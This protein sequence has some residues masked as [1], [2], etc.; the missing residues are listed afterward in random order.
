MNIIDKLKKIY[1]SNKRYN[2]RIEYDVKSKQ[3]VLKYKNNIIVYLYSDTK[4]NLYGIRKL[5]IWVNNKDRFSIFI[6]TY[7]VFGDYN[8]CSMHNIYGDVIN[9]R[10]IDLNYVEEDITFNNL[11]KHSLKILAPY[12]KE[13]IRQI[14]SAAKIENTEITQEDLLN[15]LKQSTG[16]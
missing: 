11:L 14:R 7:T 10:E 13:E 16:E 2:Y 1:Y 8:I 5:H 4:L 15:Y 9:S 12:V 3:Y 6:N